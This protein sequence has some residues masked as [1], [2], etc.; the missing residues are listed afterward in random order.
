MRGFTKA[1]ARA[2]HMLSS[3]FGST[4]KIIDP[5]FDVLETRF[6]A[7][8]ASALRARKDTAS[9]HECVLGMLNSGVA[10]VDGF[11]KLAA[12]LGSEAGDVVGAYPQAQKTLDALPEYEAILAE[13]RETLTPEVELLE[14][15]IINPLRDLKAAVQAIR[16]NVTKRNHK[17]VDLERHTASWEKVRD[18]EARSSREMGNVT[19]AEQAYEVAKA[20]YEYF[21]NALK[22]EL[23]SFFVLAARLMAP[24][25]HT[26]YYLQLNIF[27]LSF[28]AIERFANDK[29]PLKTKLSA[30][31]QDY[32]AALGDAPQ[33]LEEL[34]LHKPPPP[35]AT[36]LEAAGR[37]PSAADAGATSPTSESADGPEHDD[38]E[39][40]HD[41]SA[42]E[43]K[44]NEKDEKAAASGHEELPPYVVALFDFV[45]Q[46]EGDLSFVAGDHIQ[47]VSRTDSREDW[48]TGKVNGIQGVFPGNYSRDP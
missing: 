20:D 2:P 8:E 32:T 17:L 13:V 12:P 27:Y 36:I 9:Y 14:S 3:S 48:W 44:K 41:L 25:W 34:N 4:T 33:H 30:I 16:K 45:A 38:H 10:F 31:A 29:Y 15:R 35:S 26:L 7:L 28:R 42:G 19:K 23:P 43:Q 5:D 18:K 46:A 40:D 6:A 11:R 22:A 1:I 47:L 39:R 37:G 21:N 24:L